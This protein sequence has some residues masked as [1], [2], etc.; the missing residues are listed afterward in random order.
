M[1]HNIFIYAM[2]HYISKNNKE[3]FILSTSIEIE[4]KNVPVQMQANIT[5]LTSKQKVYVQKYMQSVFDRNFKINTTTKQQTPV[6]SSKKA[7]WKIW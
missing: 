1:N 6:D 4:D 5:N 2:V 7:W 3:Y